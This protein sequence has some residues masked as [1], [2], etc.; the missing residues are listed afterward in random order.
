VSG[1]DFPHITLGYVDMVFFVHFVNGFTI[2]LAEAIT[3]DSTV[4]TASK[5]TN[6]T[7]LPNFQEDSI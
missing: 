3:D 2:R 6:H 1:Q 4:T 7:S 5:R